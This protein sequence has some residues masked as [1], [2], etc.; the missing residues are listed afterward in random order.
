MLL[1]LVKEKFKKTSI[2]IWNNIKRDYVIN[3]NESPMYK[4]VKPYRIYAL[5]V[6][7]EWNNIWRVLVGLKH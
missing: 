5:N 6:G 3:A 2:W 4:E 1:P 7:H